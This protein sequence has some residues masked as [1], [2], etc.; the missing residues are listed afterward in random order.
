MGTVM[1]STKTPSPKAV[2]RPPL[3]NQITFVTNAFI[4]T[5][6]IKD[7]RFDISCYGGFLKEI[8]K[9]LG[10][11]DA[12]DAAVTALI[13]AFS[14]LHTHEQSRDGLVKYVHALKTLRMYLGDPVRAREPNTLCAIYLIMICQV[15]T[16]L[17]SG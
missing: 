11:N 6:E 13:S 5:F 1:R 9:R 16:P 17:R 10:K 3:S 15:S 12:L 8:P 4:S 7:L 2:V 14:S